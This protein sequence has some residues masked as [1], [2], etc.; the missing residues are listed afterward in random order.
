LLHFFVLY[1]V[2]QNYCKEYERKQYSNE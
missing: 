1:N 2:N